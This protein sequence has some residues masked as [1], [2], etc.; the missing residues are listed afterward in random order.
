MKNKTK[1]TKSAPKMECLLKISGTDTT[2]NTDD[3]LR[4]LEATV[5][6]TDFVATTALETF[7]EMFKQNVTHNISHS[8]FQG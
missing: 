8:T 6:R 5:E 4:I 1:R 7:R 2:R 3:I